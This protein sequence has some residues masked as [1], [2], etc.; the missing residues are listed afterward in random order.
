VEVL[1]EG[2][3]EGDVEG[4]VLG[5][6]EVVGE[7]DAVGEDQSKENASQ[8]GFAVRKINGAGSRTRAARNKMR[9]RNFNAFHIRKVEGA[10]E[11]V[12][13][14]VLNSNKPK[15]LR[16]AIAVLVVADEARPTKVHRDALAKVN[17]F[18]NNRA[19]Q[20]GNAAAINGL[21]IVELVMLRDRR[22]Y[23]VNVARKVVESRARAVSSEMTGGARRDEM[24][25][26]VVAEEDR[27]VD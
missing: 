15:D 13:A 14:A 26:K 10:A 3:R 23:K 5:E 6:V 16:R 8:S 4:E 11:F 27:E 18:G 20:S 17:G 24:L 21:A 22:R 2:E 12:R 25:R 19:A 7:G 9:I 1:G